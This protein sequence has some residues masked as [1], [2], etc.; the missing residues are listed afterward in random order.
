MA[1]EAGDGGR[2]SQAVAGNACL[3]FAELRPLCGGTAGHGYFCRIFA[4]SRAIEGGEEAE[5][6][7]LDGGGRGAIDV[8]GV[9][10][11]RNHSD[12]PQR[13]FFRADGGA[14]HGT[15]AGAGA[16]FS[17]FRA[18]TGP[19]TMGAAGNLGPAAAFD[20][21]ERESVADCRIWI[22]RQGSGEAGES[23]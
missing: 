6:D 4:A 12:K 14:H 20:G 15:A 1:A 11:I 3:A 23:V 7:S 10:R 21:V 5:M 16:E 19:R 22:D 13:N 17:R 2:H 9:A 18:R 8:P